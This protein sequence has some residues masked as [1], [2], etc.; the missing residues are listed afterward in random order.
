MFG[1]KRRRNERIEKNNEKISEIRRK[2]QDLISAVH[3]L[4]QSLTPEQR[5]WA[6]LYA[7]SLGWREVTP[8]WVRRRILSEAKT[9]FLDEKDIG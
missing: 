5:A 2:E 4:E 8:T 6:F 9:M 1:M 3:L 7:Q